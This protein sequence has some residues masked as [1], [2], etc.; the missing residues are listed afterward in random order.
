MWLTIGGFIFFVVAN[1][2]H[3]Q[4]LSQNDAKQVELLKLKTG[5]ILNSE[6]IKNDTVAYSYVGD[7]VEQGSKILFN[8]DNDNSN[9]EI[10]SD[11]QLKLYLSDTFYRDKDNFVKEIQYATT[12]N[13]IWQ[14]ANVP[15]MIDEVVSYF[16]IANVLADTST[17]TI[18]GDC[19]LYSYAALQSTVSCADAN[20]AVGY[21]ATDNNNVGLFKF[22]LPSGTGTITDVE[23]YLNKYGG[24]Y[25]TT[26][27]LFKIARTDVDITA[28]TYLVYKPGSNWQT[29]GALGANDFVNTVVDHTKQNATNGWIDLGIMGDEA[30]DSLTLDWEDSVTLKLVG[31]DP[32]NYSDQANYRSAEYA[33][34]SSRPYVLITY[35]PEATS[36]PPATAS[37]TPMFCSWPDNTDISI[38]SGCIVNY[39]ASTSAT[40]SIEMIYYKI[41]F[42]LYWF[43]F[44]IFVIGLIIVAIVLFNAK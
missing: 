38:V 27:N 39:A 12:T 37:T 5:Q 19:M 4:A 6:I 21:Y 23:L 18:N 11:T 42:L 26:L 16:K 20:V 10:I 7:E 14:Q 9:L 34:V 31:A 8:K 2:I 36:T 28:A 3:A 25:D 33:T 32:G 29:A 15:T 44:S 35:T 17:T 41:P 13:K 40:T 1:N 43:V 22:T 24:T 30:D